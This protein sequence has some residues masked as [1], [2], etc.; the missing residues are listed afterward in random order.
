MSDSGLPK[1]E[2]SDIIHALDEV[3]NSQVDTTGTTN[4]LLECITS[5]VLRGAVVMLG[6][7]DSTVR[8]TAEYVALMKKLI[9]NDLVI[10]AI[11]YPVTVAQ[12]AGLLNPEAKDQCG[13]GLK[14]VCEL[15]EIPPVLPLGGLE[16]I[17]NVVAIAQALSADS[18]LAVSSLPVVGCDA[19]G[20]SAQAVELGNTFAGLG[21]DTFIGIMPYEGSLEDVIAASGLK[22]GAEAKHTV[23]SDLNELGD[24]I[25]AD[26]EKK[27]ASIAI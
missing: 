22:D 11:G 13:A 21:V 15:A 16:N 14:R 27:R 2:V 20:V 1:L 4:P 6:C 5:G 17:G 3:S 9:A 23:S 12:N 18:G 24:A 19:A 25:L 8:D 26:I 10:L 7:D